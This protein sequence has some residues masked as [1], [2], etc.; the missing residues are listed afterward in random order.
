[1]FGLLNNRLHELIYQASKQGFFYF[2]N[3]DFPGMLGKSIADGGLLILSRF[4]ITNYCFVPFRYGVLSDA[5]AEKGLLYAKIKIQSTYLH[6]FTAHLQ[7]SYIDSS[8]S[9]FVSRI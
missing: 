1:M 2:T 9:Q 3:V 5:L 8:E 4:P 7:A 6:L